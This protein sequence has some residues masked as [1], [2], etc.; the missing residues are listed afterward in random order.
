MGGWV[1]HVTSEW[2]AKAQL[3][4]SLFGVKVVLPGY[5]SGLKITLQSKARLAAELVVTYCI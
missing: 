2:Q 1:L 4:H 5:K 3:F